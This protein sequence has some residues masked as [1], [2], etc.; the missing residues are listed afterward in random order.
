MFSPRRHILF[1]LAVTGL[2]LV[3][4]P[5]TQAYVLIVHDFA[6]GLQFVAQNE[7][8][9]QSW[10]QVNRA[11]QIWRTL[12]YALPIGRP[13]AYAVLETRWR[14]YRG[15][16]E[17]D[18]FDAYNPLRLGL[19]HGD[20]DGQG[21]QRTAVPIPV[22]PAA[23]RDAV[24]PATRQQLA[25]TYRAILTIDGAA[26]LAV[27]QI[28]TNRTAGK[29]TQRALTAIELDLATRS[30]GQ[31]ALL[32][33]LAGAALL[34]ARDG[35]LRNTTLNHLVELDLAEQLLWRETDRA[36]LAVDAERRQSYAAV[37]ERTRAGT[38]ELIHGWRLR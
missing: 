38:S 35:Q 6:L 10:E 1:A 37:A 29:T 27:H 18:P 20:P 22:Y 17:D 24:S 11:R 3:S 21:Y 34:D 26:Q 28:A 4:A 5:A 16:G 30:S 12:S 23:A 8:L 14:E 25:E 19:I 32:Q 15:T 2:C 7:R 9:R 36:Q 33:D 13:I 31:V